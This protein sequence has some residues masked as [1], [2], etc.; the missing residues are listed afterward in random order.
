VSRF[1][2]DTDFLVHALGSRGPAWRRLREL[3][4]EDAEIEMS[5]IA[6]YEFARGPRSPEQLAVARALFSEEA[7]I[8]FSEVHAE[9]AAD[10]F[11]ALGGPRR[12]AADIAVGVIAL[13]RGAT[14]LTGNSRDYTGID[15]LLLEPM[16]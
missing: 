1:H 11:R 15:G 16:R 12:R 8:S 3:N 4:D 7:V 6:W 14:L 10:V 9:R 13:D 5:A 2:I